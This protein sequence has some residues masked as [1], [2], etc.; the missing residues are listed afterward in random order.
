MVGVWKEMTELGRKTYLRRLGCFFCLT[1][2]TT[3]GWTGPPPPPPPPGGGYSPLEQP[4]NCNASGM[5]MMISTCRAMLVS[6][7]KLYATSCASTVSRRSF[8]ANDR[9]IARRDDR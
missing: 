5:I 4:G 3:T 8:G 6:I 1:T 2:F 9:D 7:L